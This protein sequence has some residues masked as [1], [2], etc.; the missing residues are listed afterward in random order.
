MKET[1]LDS[2]NGVS[3]L[4]IR[5]NNNN[6]NNNNTNNSTAA[7]TGPRNRNQRNSDHLNEIKDMMNS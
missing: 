1:R 6:S 4:L 3:P 2:E 7:G 5:N